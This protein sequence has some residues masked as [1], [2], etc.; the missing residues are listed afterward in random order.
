MNTY[1]N[2][3]ISYS[4]IERQVP[5]RDTFIS[6]TKEYNDIQDLINKRSELLFLPTY[7]QEYS[8]FEKNTNGESELFYKICLMGI[9]RDGRRINVLIDG[10]T[11]FFEVLLNSDD[12]SKQDQMKDNILTIL[13]NNDCPP[14][15]ST[16]KNAKPFK[17]YKEGKSTFLRLYYNNTKPRT[18]AIRLIRAS[19]YET[20]SDDLS[21]Y[22]RVV[23][24][25]Y[26]TSFA[27]WVSI[28]KY[29]IEYLRQ[30]KGEVFRVHI[31]NYI[32]YAKELKDDLLRDRTLSCCWDIETW[33]REGN[34]P[35]PEN[36]DDNIFCLSMTFQ[37]VHDAEPF[38]KVC[39]C[40][41]PADPDPAYM[42]IVCGSE[43]NIMEGFAH[44]IKKFRP[45]FIVGFNDSDYDWR[46]VVNR[47]I[48][49]PGLL[50]RMANFMDCTEPY[51]P[52]TDKFIFER[53]Y[54]HNVIKLEATTN[55]DSYTLCLPGYISIDVRT[56]LR[57]LAPTA[58][59]SSLKFFLKENKLESKDEMP[60]TELFR[61]NSVYRDFVEPYTTKSLLSGSII[62]ITAKDSDTEKYEYLK[63]RLRAINHYCMVD[64]K[65]LHYLLKKKCVFMDHR[66]LSHSAYTSVHDAFFKA[67]GMKVRQLTIAIGQQKPFY[68]RFSNINAEGAEEGKYPGAFVL[69]PKK[70]LNVTK[71]SIA[72]RIEVANNSEK[73]ELLGGKYTEW[74]NT[75]KEE[76][77]TY[78]KIV[79]EHGAI[80]SHEIVPN[81]PQVPQHFIDFWME[82]IK[83]P[84]VGLD[85][86]SL[87]P[88]LMRA[89]NFS[90]EMCI[91]DRRYAQ[92]LANSGVGLTKVK[93]MFQGNVRRAWFVKHNNK[94]D[95]NDTDFK[96]GVF[97]YILDDLFGKRSVIKQQM[98]V[99]DKRLEIIA[100]MSKEERQQPDIQTE[101]DNLSFMRGYIN[102]KQNAL[103]VFMNTF[104]GEAGNKRSPFFVMEVA[105][106]VTSYGQI[107]I[108]EAYRI[109]NEMK[110]DVYYG[111]TDSLYLAVP[112]HHFTQL[113]TN[114]YAGKISK[115][116]YWTELVKLT[117]KG[118]DEVRDAVNSFF[119]KDNGTKFLTMAYE[120]VLYPV[121]FAAKKKYLGVP[122]E[123]IPNF[124]PDKLFIRG[125]EI[126][127]RGVSEILRKVSSELMWKL[128]DY[129]NTYEVIELVRI[130]IDEIYGRMWDYK[131]FIQ[132]GVYRPNKKNV[133]ICTLVKRMEEKGIAIKPNER[134]D[135][136][137]VKKYPYR[138]D[139]RG[140]KEALSIGDKLEITEEFLKQGMEIDLDYYMQ[141]GINGQLARLIAYHED[142]KV[143]VADHDTDALK[144]AEV[145]MYNNACKYI[146]NY[147]AKYY[148]SYNTF[149]KTYQKIFKTS[150]SILTSSVAEYDSFAGTI[151]S[152]NVSFDNFAEWYMSH[153]EK[154]VKKATE[155]YGISFVTKWLSQYP[156]NQQAKYSA[157]I[158]YCYYGNK[159][160]ISAKREL[161]FNNKRLLLQKRIADGHANVIKSFKAYTSGIAKL[162]DAIKEKLNITSDLCKPIASDTNAAKEFTL[163][164]FIEEPELS[165]HI[166]WDIRQTA[167]AETLE[168]F[169]NSEFV[170]AITELKK[171]YID[172]YAMY[173]IIY[174]TRNITMFL[175]VKRD[176][177]NRFVQ[178]PDDTYVKNMVTKDRDIT[179]VHN[180][181]I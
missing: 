63:D 43:R 27:S 102:C 179:E 58:E 131:D 142:F 20:A 33:S 121:L 62:E 12:E 173:S 146:E 162:N 17:Y 141:G 107:N 79:E 36:D 73:Q 76:L 2:L 133:K 127:K 115:L 80:G 135:Y 92:R 21:S 169:S 112:E 98:K 3:C 163:T 89:Y 1:H 143:D 171:L 85:F 145:T 24:R 108:K 31:S 157:L 101:Y 114:Y 156:R 56:I 9:F 176:T 152:A 158:Q 91:L 150:N 177:K 144:K 180:L 129:E 47:A 53:M 45:E 166:L 117:M 94:Y 57:K 84:I 40:D 50:T 16:Y 174:K 64:S 87:Y 22:Y 71:L 123:H 37:W 153:I 148:S 132:T 34:V 138:Y 18:A 109:V 137:I 165:D 75:T 175:K 122:H 48:K 15:K 68:I 167:N 26:L 66:E 134:F 60:Y 90:P 10:I 61:I 86:A 105:A 106:G 51:K 4:S 110:C 13:E 168:L 81:I 161:D 118:I 100:A 83:R 147:C 120:E 41:K 35:Q 97:P 104:Y 170:K 14:V 136:V 59:Q 164:D 39:L 82:K 126:K 149:G 178:R 93:F 96:F 159:E 128:C 69:P 7:L 151:L 25:D 54:K 5:T 11:P 124:K 52:H 119:V 99:I 130:K 28:K 44:I 46:W 139:W 103:K 70:G 95:P 6:N 125:F 88:S 67:N 181:S 116:E 65:V 172:T 140:R 38:F 42:T 55:I 77:E 160:A 29:S 32:R 19:G 113:D 72:E 30:I 74:K 154:K 111:D 78:H 49:Y 155:K 8:I 23:C